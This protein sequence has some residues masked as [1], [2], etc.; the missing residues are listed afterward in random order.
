MHK[1]VER[2]IEVRKVIFSKV[3]TL[4]DGPSQNRRLV[5]RVTSCLKRQSWCCRFVEKSGSPQP[6]QAYRRSI[7]LCSGLCHLS[8][9]RPREDIYK[10]QCRTW[11]DQV[12]FGGSILIPSAPYGRNE[13]SVW[14]K[15]D[16]QDGFVQPTTV[17]QGSA[18]ALPTP[19][20]LAFC[21]R[22]LP[23]RTKPTY[24]TTFYISVVS[25]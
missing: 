24:P 23:T 4:H 21:L 18:S 13:K 11:N 9:N 7:S 25:V 8:E 6:L 12:S 20:G 1:T 2:S 3:P 14:L 19:A 15:S 5:S 16:T 22:I 10:R 17:S